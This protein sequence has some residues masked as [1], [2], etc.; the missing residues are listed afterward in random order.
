MKKISTLFGYSNAD[1]MCNAVASVI[2]EKVA[3]VD[4]VFWRFA[5]LQRNYLQILALELKQFKG[6]PTWES[7]LGSG[8]GVSA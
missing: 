3:V 5:T 8:N 4:L 6:V 1:D 2:D 7:V